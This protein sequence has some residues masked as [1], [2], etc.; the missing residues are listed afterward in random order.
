MALVLLV[1]GTDVVTVEV[2][3]HILG[4]LVNYGWRDGCVEEEVGFGVPVCYGY[5]RTPNED[6]VKR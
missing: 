2:A 6:G 5:M 3:V 1:M 4:F